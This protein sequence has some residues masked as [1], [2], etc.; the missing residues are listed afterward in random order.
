MTTRP[1]RT[2]RDWVAEIEPLMKPVE[3]HSSDRS[4]DVCH[5]FRDDGGAI[6]SSCRLTTRQV[7]NPI[8]TVV[9]IATTAWDTQLHTILRRYKSDYTRHPDRQLMRIRLAAAV[10]WF[11]RQHR[12]C[13]GEWN[14]IAVVPSSVRTP[15]HPLST[16]IDISSYLRGQQIAPLVLGADPPRK[17]RASNHGYETTQDVTDMRIL[18]LDDTFTSGASVQSAATTLTSAGAVVVCAVVIGRFVNP[19]WADNE[20]LWEELAQRHF[21]WNTCCIHP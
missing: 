4:C 3:H 14:A 16:V 2:I 6:C 1:T 17:R 19:E 18:L 10:T 13:I 12:T 15:P 21:D 9:P 7:T 20:P 5:G 8:M 11:L